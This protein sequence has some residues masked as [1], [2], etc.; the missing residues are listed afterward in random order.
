MIS[1]TPQT[2]RF[3]AQ[4][5][6]KANDRTLAQDP[7]TPLQHCSQSASPQTSR[8]TQAAPLPAPPRAQ[9]RAELR[10]I[11]Q[12]FSEHKSGTAGMVQT[13]PRRPP[14]DKMTPKRKA[15]EPHG[16]QWKGAG[17]ARQCRT[18][19]APGLGGGQA[20][21]VTT[22]GSSRKYRTF[23]RKLPGIMKN[24]SWAGRGP[25]PVPPCWLTW[26]GSRT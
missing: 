25:G 26:T 10:V 23:S 2:S 7:G 18:Q 3:F 16:T 1:V 13:T 5:Y 12:L 14:L 21:V 8:G 17:K 24:K 9:Q 4:V 22:S 11:L 19:A 6:G 15:R 20:G